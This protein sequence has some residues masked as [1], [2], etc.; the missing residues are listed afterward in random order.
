MRKLEGLTKGKLIELYANNKKSLEDIGNL[1]KV[2]RVA[3]YKKL[4]KYGV[5]QR[6]KSQARI[7]AQKQGKLPQQFFEINESFFSNWSPEMAYVLGLVITDGCISQ[8]G[9]VSLCM[10]DKDLLEKVKEAM[11]SAHKITSSKH[12]KGLY[13]YHFSREKMVEDL[14]KLGVVPRKSLI[15]KFPE[16]PQEYLSDFIRGVFDGDGSVFYDKR[17][18]KFPLRSKFVSGSKDFIEGLEEGLEFLGMPKR[19]IYRQKT[20]NGFSYMFIYD[21]KNSVKL[22]DT[23]YK[24]AQNGLFLDRKYRRFLEGLKGSLEGGTDNG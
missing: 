6:S 3:I 20:K 9:T 4:K 1:Y 11:G 7:E 21:H 2:S 18:P 16:V 23:L 19:T 22:F 17:R 13:Y 8:S 5:K 15:V 12:Q 24:N 10:N 14:E